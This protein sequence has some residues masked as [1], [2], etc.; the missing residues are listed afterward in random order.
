MRRLV[1]ALF[2]LLFSVS[3]FGQSS[4]VFLDAP[5]RVRVW[6][7]K[8]ENPVA[9]SGQFEFRLGGKVV[10]IRAIK[11]VGSPVQERR[12]PRTPGRV[13]IAGTLQS[14]LGG[15]EWNPDDD[16]TQMS[17]DSPGVFSL[18]VELPKGN[19]E[20]KITRNGSWDENYGKDMV[21]NGANISLRV[22]VPSAVKFVVDFNQNLILT[23]IDN[24]DRVP[25]PPA[26]TPTQRPVATDF[27]TFDVFLKQPVGL[28]S[29]SLPMSLRRRNDST[30]IVIVREALSVPELRYRGMDLG[31]RWTPESTTFRVWSPI[32]S[33]TDLL[34]FKTATGQLT[35]TVPMVRS[36][37]GTWAAK[38]KGN[39]HGVFYLYR[40]SSYGETRTATDINCFSASPDSKRSMV[41]NLAKTNPKEWKSPTPAPNWSPVDSILYEIHVRDFTIHPSS[42]VRDKWR[43]TYLGLAQDG[44]SLRSKQNFPTGL[45]YLEYLGVTDI[46]LLPIQNFLNRPGEY[47]WGYAT[48]LFNVP[49]ES[50]SSTPNDPLGVIRDVKTMVGALHE[51]GLRVVMDVVYNHTWPPTGQDS[52]F[53]QTVPYYYFRTNDQGEVLNESGVGNALHDERPMVRKFVRDSLLYWQKEYHIDGFRFD[54]IGMFTPESVIDWTKALRAVRPDTTLYG[55]PWTGGGPT[56]FGKGQ[57]RRTGMAVFNDNFRNTFRGELDGPGTGYL[58]GAPTSLQALT[59]AFM[60]SIEDFTDSPAETVN[61]IS[62]HDNLT[63]RDKLALSS[64]PQLIPNQVEM[65][66]AAVLLSQG[67]PFLEGGVE[68]G[69]SKG[70]NKNSYDAG[71]AVNQYVWSDLPKHLNMVKL[72]R[73]L[74]ELRKK[75]PSLRLRTASAVR[76]L[77][78][79]SLQ[80]SVS[81]T[82]YRA[83][84]EVEYVL[85]INPTPNVS[86]IDL[87]RG[88]WEDALNPRTK[89][90]AKTAVVP[91]QSALVLQTSGR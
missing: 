8:P 83:K 77:V 73:K 34:L 88:R 21:R 38:V 47:T 32:S 71:D 79:V 52:A 89:V 87:P 53:W 85:A 48:N 84:K 35:S 54:L 18:V 7:A 82:H 31:S 3:A 25:T 68:M 11:P 39:L 70:G 49:E 22:S 57:Q 37:N 58:Q 40:F 14:A 44:T 64:P 56:R 9:L 69:R 28:Q 80:G 59:P 17:E 23:S 65:A 20:Y 15:K 72:Y 90:I 67:I 6:V 51:K 2:A 55:E 24:P 19:F 81:V 46:H 16:I 29:Y 91:P 66:G 76:S 5:D 42:G 78:T 30:R 36:A 45:D 12:L 1:L 33:K 27:D 62:A 10:P 61:Y 75:S 4:P 41:I 43:G 86:T 74:I 63:L 26:P 60:G 50:Y 13:V